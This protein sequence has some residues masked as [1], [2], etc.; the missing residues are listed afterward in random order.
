MTDMIII[1]VPCADLTEAKKIGSSVMKKRLTPCY[2]IIQNTFSAAFWPPDTGEIE[3]VSGA[4]LLIKSIES[5]Y[6]RIEEEIKSIHSDSNPC[7]FSIP[8]AN[9]SETYY[10]WLR[11]EIGQV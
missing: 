4:V 1:Y 6:T 2:N 11:G 9:V 8:V 7:I 10:Q 5:Q 3:E